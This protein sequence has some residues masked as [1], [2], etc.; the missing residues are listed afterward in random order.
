MIALDKIIDN[1]LDNSFILIDTNFIIEYYKYRKDFENLIKLLSLRK[2]TYFTLHEIYL[3]FI[4]G[5]NIRQITKKKKDLW[6]TL[7]I[8]TLNVDPE[9]RSNTE[10]IIEIYRT[11]GEKLDITDFYLG[12]T[13]MKFYDSKTLLL[14]SNVKHFNCN[15][16]DIKYVL[17]VEH[18]ELISTFYLYKFSIKKYQ[19]ALEKYTK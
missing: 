12:A 16:F 18:E 2:C 10:K 9:I 15:L 5:S 4:R 8:A 19:K 1:N 14:T 7:K 3:E 17:P 6:N 13:L 11:K